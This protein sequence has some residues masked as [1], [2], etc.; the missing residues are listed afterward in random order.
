LRFISRRSRSFQNVFF[1]IFFILK[2]KVRNHKVSIFHFCF[3]YFFHL[4]DYTGGGAGGGGGGGGGVG[5]EVTGSTF[6]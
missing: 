3:N 2:G 5:L 1:V 4:S 6:Q